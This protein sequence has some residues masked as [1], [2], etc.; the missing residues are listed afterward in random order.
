[1]SWAQ[2]VEEASTVEAK[3]AVLAE[4]F[5]CLGKPPAR[6]VAKRLPSIETRHLESV[7]VRRVFDHWVRVICQVA[8]G[9]AGYKLTPERRQKIQ[10]RLRDG[11]SVLDMC[12]AIDGCKTSDYHMARGEYRLGKQYNDLTLILRNGSKLEWFRDMKDDGPDMTAFL[13]V[14]A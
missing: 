4:A 3:L 10:A 6:P 5:D 1:M 14:A 2:R 9:K 8:P 11:Y 12:E 13:R 7:D